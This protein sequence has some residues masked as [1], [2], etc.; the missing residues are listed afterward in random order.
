MD[1][2][3]EES[4]VRLTSHQSE[5]GGCELGVEKVAGRVNNGLILANTH[6]LM[7]DPILPRDTELIFRWVKDLE[8]GWEAK[9]RDSPSAASAKPPLSTGPGGWAALQ[10]FPLAFVRAALETG[11]VQKHYTPPRVWERGGSFCAEWLVIPPP[12]R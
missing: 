12:R 9:P 8:A 4:K 6:S 2:V 11:G 3:G 1:F 7:K 5:E 10:G